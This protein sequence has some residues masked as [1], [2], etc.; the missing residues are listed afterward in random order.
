MDTEQY[1]KYISSRGLL[2]SCDIY[3][4]TPISGISNM[5]NYNLNFQGKINIHHPTIYVCIS[6]LKYFIKYIS[7]TILY[8]YIL[9]TGDNDET[10]PY[11]LLTEEEFKQFISNKNLIHWFSQNCALINNEKLSQIPI[12]LDYHTMSFR[13]HAWGKKTTPMNQENILINIKNK[14]LPF[15]ERI[16]KIYSNFHFF[17]ETKF[18]YDRK[19]ALHKISK[20]LLYCE[21]YKVERDKSWE[22]QSKYTFVASPHGNGLDC[23][24]T[25]EALCLGCIPIVK[26]SI[27]DELYVDLP[28]LIVKEWS[29]VSQKLLDETIVKF[30]NMTFNYEKLTLNYWKNKI[31]SYK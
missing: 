5:I 11:D 27:L 8:E 19:D 7:N 20:D 21:P 31:N 28:V 17:M 30:K 2:K 29:N 10:C 18:G 9:V 12:G 16:N 13:D 6:S 24:R 3:S 23:H 26:T 25:W 1:C 14:S 4:L 22:N 15:Y